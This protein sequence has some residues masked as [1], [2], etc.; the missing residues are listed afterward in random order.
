MDKPHI[1][2][3]EIRKT[4]TVRKVR[5]GRNEIRLVLVKSELIVRKVFS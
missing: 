2:V 3:I 1:I 4:L 5:T